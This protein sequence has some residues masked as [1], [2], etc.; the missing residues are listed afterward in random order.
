MIGTGVRHMKGSIAPKLSDKMLREFHRHWEL[1]TGA[2]GV[3]H[4][5]F[6]T[7]G[8]TF[9]IEYVDTWDESS[10]KHTVELIVGKAVNLV[11]LKSP[12]RKVTYGA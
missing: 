11:D 4:P 3:P 6:R 8:G 9:D 7:D 12:R 10:L 1:Q 2:K 5:L